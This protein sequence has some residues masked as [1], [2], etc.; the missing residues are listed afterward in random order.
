MLCSRRNKSVR[1]G[2]GRAFG[3]VVPYA[4][5]HEDHIFHTY[6]PEYGERLIDLLGTGPDVVF[7]FVDKHKVECEPIRTGLLFAA[8][9]VAAA[10][11]LEKRAKFW[12]ARSAPV[13]I[14]EFDTLERVVGSRYY[15]LAL[16]DKR[17]GCVNPL[18][19][20]RGLAKAA[21]EKNVKLFEQS[22]VTGIHRQDNRWLLKTASGEVLADFVVLATDGYTDDLWPGLRNSIIPI[23]AYHIVSSPLSENLRRSILPGG[24]S[25]T[26]SR[27]LY[28]GIC[29]ARGRPPAYE[30]GRPAVL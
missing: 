12:Q 23:R 3:Q 9:T 22:R 6:G 13:E 4:K 30:R 5:H 7:S 27:R 25:L 15:P 21:I 18:G 11:R 29:I 8:H 14:L 17:G 19:Y 16:L 10:G 28:S 2:S 1:G 26:D 20:A 24:Q